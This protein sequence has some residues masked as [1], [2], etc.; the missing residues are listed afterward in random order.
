MDAQPK[1][2]GPPE[3]RVPSFSPA[4]LAAWCSGAWDGAPA[5]VCGVSQDGQKIPAGALFVAI[6]GERFDGHAFVEQAA[7][8][9]AAAALVR[10]DWPRPGG[11]L[12]PLLR[13][14]DTRRALTALA[15][16]YRA[17]FTGLAA[18]ITGS[19][20]KTTTKEMI[21]ACFR[22]GGQAAATAGN[23]NNDLGLPLSLL[24]A[25]T[26]MQRGIFELGSN[27][28]G[29]IAALARLLRPDAATVTAIG[30]VHI[31]HFGTVEAIAEEKADLLRAVPAGGFVVLDADS[32]W[33]DWLSRQ[34]A[35]RVVTVSLERPAVDYRGRLLDET[36]DAIEVIER[37]SGC[38]QRFRTGLHGRH[39]AS[40]LLLAIGLA[41]GA[42][43]PFELLP[44]AMKDL[45]LPPMRWQQV[46]GNG[47]SIVNDAYNANSVS[48]L[49]ALR[50]FAAQPAT[51]RRV[52]VLGDMRELGADAE[53]LHREVGR[54]VAGGPWQALICV[55]TQAGWIGDEAVSGGFPAQQVWRYADAA[56]AAK[57]N[58]EWV[59][60]GD[61]LLLKAS[62]G[63]G[64]EVV[65]A[66]LLS[67]ESSQSC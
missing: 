15:R 35:A 32:P 64:L 51:G 45:R 7:A 48:M 59:K 50:T 53:A 21:A 13:V 58:L 56:A 9:G 63:V 36:G 16:G 24:A 27:H 55:G 11:F 6:K 22:A 31:E 57:A 17:T 23:L 61:T 46:R 43:V 19:A 8:R 60:P 67:P 12:L 10:R 47:L 1:G 29:E 28:P 34:T 25:P 62:R 42:G 39:Q 14:E 4:R 66:A 54:A 30:P 52:L 37:S 40:N 5:A 33:C 18:G 49:C 65:A 38:A 20:G 41:R 44:G 2:A 26:D 3:A